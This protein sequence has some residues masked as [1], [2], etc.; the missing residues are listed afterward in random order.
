MRYI[1]TSST[2]AVSGPAH[3][4]SALNHRIISLLLP[5]VLSACGQSD[6]EL[7]ED[8]QEKMR[9]CGGN[10]VSCPEN[11]ADEVREQYECIM[12]TECNEIAQCAK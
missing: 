1:D 7:C 6:K 8:V 10:T 4:E 2:R 11:L 9:K 3:G 5:V 12:D